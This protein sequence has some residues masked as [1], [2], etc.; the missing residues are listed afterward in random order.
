MYDD[1]KES[2]DTK[3]WL[4]TY[5][6]KKVYILKDLIDKYKTIAKRK[7]WMILKFFIKKAY[8][9]FII[10]LTNSYYNE[11]ISRIKKKD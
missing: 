8:G 3:K 6:L 4:V 9:F 2:D 5:S 11:I 10:K 7:P 1:A